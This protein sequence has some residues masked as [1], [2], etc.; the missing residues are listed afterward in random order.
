[1]KRDDRVYTGHML[2]TAEKALSKIQGKDRADFDK[3]EDLRMVLTH[4]IQIVGEAAAHVSQEYKNRNP[5]IPW[6][7]I[8][9][10]RHKI[11]HDYLYVDYDRI[12]EV[13]TLDLP[14]LVSAL[15]EMENA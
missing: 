11:V 2:D 8:V 5:Q 1:M 10:M 13:V 14:S 9:G 6:R 12:W 15:S 4:L 7:E 3:D